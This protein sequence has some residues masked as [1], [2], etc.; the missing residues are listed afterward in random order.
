MAAEHVDASETPF[1]ERLEDIRRIHLELPEPLDVAYAIGALAGLRTGEVF[2]LRWAHVDLPARRIHV[3]ESVKGPL[4]DKDSR[5]VPILDALLPILTAWREETGGDGRIIPAMRCDGEKIDKHTPG[6]YLR[7]ALEKL[8]LTRPGLGWY[9]ATRH[10]FASHWVMAGGSIEKLKEILGHYSVVVTERYAHLRPDL[11]PASDL[12]T[13]TLDM[14]TDPRDPAPTREQN[15][16]R[17]PDPVSQPPESRAKM[18]EPPCKPSSVPWPSRAAA[19]NIPLGRALPRAS[20]E[21]NPEARP[22]QSRSARSRSRINRRRLA[23]PTTASLFAL[24]PGGVCH[25]APVTRRAVRS[26]RTVSP[27]PRA[28]RGA[29]RRSA[30]CCTVLRVAPTGR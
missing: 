23:A 30:F 11:F 28:P 8:G 22:G 26:Y 19:A 16:I 13:I 5:M 25:A 20:S 6:I 29:V 14:A 10:T 21:L 1:I 24:A 2:A 7:A 12:A 18:P 27:L 15:G 17:A 9:E 4:K 3:R